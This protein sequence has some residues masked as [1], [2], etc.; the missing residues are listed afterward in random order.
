MWAQLQVE[1]NQ[2]VDFVPMIDRSG[3]KVLIDHCA[4]PYLGDGTHCPGIQAL[5]KFGSKR[6]NRDQD[7][8]LFKVLI[9]PLPL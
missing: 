8:R 7:L 6:P 4:R 1:G 9:A 5:K 3:V 2:L